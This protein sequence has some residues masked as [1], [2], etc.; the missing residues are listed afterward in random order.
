MPIFTAAAQ[1]IGGGVF[2][3]K[4]RQNAEK[5]KRRKTMRVGKGL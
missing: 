3:D 5:G 2:A 4:K 1:E